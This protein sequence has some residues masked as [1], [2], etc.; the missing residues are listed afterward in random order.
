MCILA[1]ILFF[2]KIFDSVVGSGN[3]ALLVGKMVEGVVIILVVGGGNK[4]G[5]IL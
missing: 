5:F 2:V 1:G 4:F 3:E